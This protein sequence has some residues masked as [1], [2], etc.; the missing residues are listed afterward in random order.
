[1]ETFETLEAARAAY[2][3]AE[4]RDGPSPPPGPDPMPHS[5]PEWFD[6]G[7]AGETWGEEDY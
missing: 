3:A 4:T 5:A 7:D 1:M 2:P 6:P